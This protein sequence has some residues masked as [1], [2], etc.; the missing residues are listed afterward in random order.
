MMR[1]IRLVMILL[2]FGQIVDASQDPHDAAAGPSRLLKKNTKSSKRC[3]QYDATM[4]KSA[5]RR[6][7]EREFLQQNK[8][9]ISE[10]DKEFGLL[11]F[12]FR[13]PKSE[14]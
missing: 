8:D 13:A 3:R 7:V 14:W 4:M 2:V 5:L 6:A 12:D 9:T 11:G 10:A 1:V